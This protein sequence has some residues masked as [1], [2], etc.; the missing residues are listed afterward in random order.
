MI[1]ENFV[2][3]LTASLEHFAVHVPQ[4]AAA[5][6]LVKIIDVLGDEEEFSAELLLEFRQGDMGSVGL[7]PA[8]PQIAPA[9]VVEVVHQG[10][11]AFEAFRGR[12]VLDRVFF[13]QAILRAESGNARLRRDASAGEYHD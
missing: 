1:D 3:V 13:P 9:L 11:I 10:R 8:L 5:G 12:H 4:L 2:G 6:A 7:H